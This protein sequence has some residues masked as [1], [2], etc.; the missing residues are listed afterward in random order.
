MKIEIPSSYKKILITGGAGFI[1]GCLIRKILMISDCE[2][3][4][5]DKFG[6]ASDLTGINRQIEKI[7]NAKFKKHNLIKI[8]I[9]NKDSL[10]KV[11]KNIDQI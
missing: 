2:I 9:S 10:S 1:G 6:Y 4:N 11:I 5:I 8:D 7:G 3:F